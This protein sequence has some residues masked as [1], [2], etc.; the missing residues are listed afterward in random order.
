MFSFCLKEMLLTFLLFRQKLLTCLKFQ[1]FTTKFQVKMVVS[2]KIYFWRHV[3]V[4]GDIGC[5]GVGVLCELVHILLSSSLS[6]LETEKVPSIH[7]T[8]PSLSIRSAS[9]NCPQIIS[10]Y[11]ISALI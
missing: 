1:A 9:L 3:G 4:G 7:E 10:P 5:S 2:Q 11:M 8:N 6:K